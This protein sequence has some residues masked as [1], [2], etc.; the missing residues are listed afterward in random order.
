M[1]TVLQAVAPNAQITVDARGRR[2]L[3]WAPPEE[4][5]AIKKALEQIDGTTPAGRRAAEEKLMVY[6]VQGIDATTAMQTP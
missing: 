4:Q 2:L 3:I 5:E 1:L 6:P